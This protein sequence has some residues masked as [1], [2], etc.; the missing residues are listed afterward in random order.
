[1]DFAAALTTLIA[2]AAAL[3]TAI[4]LTR[5]SRRPRTIPLL[6][7]HQPDARAV[8]SQPQQGWEKPKRRPDPWPPASQPR[9]QPP[10]QPQQGGQLPG[11][12][13]PGWEPPGRSQPGWESPGQSQPPKPAGEPPTS[14]GPWQPPT[15]RRRAPAPGSGV[16]GSGAPG[17]GAP[18]PGGAPAPTPGT[19]A[20]TA[21]TSAPAPT[22][23]GRP[24][25]LAPAPAPAPPTDPLAALTPTQQTAII[26]ALRA[27][28]AAA[29]K[30]ADR[31]ALYANLLFFT[32]GLLASILITLLI[33]P[34]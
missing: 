18:A 3:T 25:T 12:S 34:L 17:S 14:P 27:E 29:A 9:W 22:N 21:S 20:P 30:T 33:Q 24:P 31:K 32:A 15:E 13:Q 26:T 7:R 19:N 2:L 28:L 11:Q 16:P 10:G 1:M 6:T 5:Q 23:G 4:T 8:P